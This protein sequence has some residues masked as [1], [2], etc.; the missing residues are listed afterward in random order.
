MPLTHLNLSQSA[1]LSLS[2]LAD[3]NLQFLDIS[4]TKI[5]DITPLRGLPIQT[6][7]INRTRIKNLSV[8][9]ELPALEL[10]IISK[11]MIISKDIVQ[12]LQARG[13]TVETTE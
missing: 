6:L 8:I 4:R 9:L 10:L 5:T 2:F 13:V 3:K 1:V 12:L 11:K 7:N